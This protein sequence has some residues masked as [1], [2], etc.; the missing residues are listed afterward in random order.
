MMEALA[1]T[2]LIDLDK[3]R[4]T[5]LATDPYPHVIVPGF[6]AGAALAR[7]SA[8]FPPLDKPGSFPL[9]ELSYGPVFGELVEELHGP[10]LRMAMA[11]KFDIDLSG[12]PS[13]I[14][15]RGCA[16]PNDGKIHTDTKSKLITVLIYMN[17][18]WEAPGGRLRLLRSPD[19]L[20]D[21]AAEVPPLEGT[22]LAFRV[23]EHSW[24]GHEPASG[25]RRSI[26]LN[27]VT[28]PGIVRRE[29]ARHRLSA[30]IKRFFGSAY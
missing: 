2:Q 16:R 20:D 11:E 30:R 26:Q 6:L 17:A 3:F 14:T 8:D 28:D 19:S 9:D 1:A 22:L 12:R 15:I 23:S 24:H 13:M 21:Y 29:Q 25:P 4:A 18:A 10:E 7:I 27:W 5:P